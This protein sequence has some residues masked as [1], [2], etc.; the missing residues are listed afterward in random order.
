M[1]EQLRIHQGRRQRIVAGE[2]H[3]AAALRIQIHDADGE[4]MAQGKG[5]RVA[6]APG[7][8]EHQ[9]DIGP[10]QFGLR[11]YVSRGLEHIARQ[12]SGAKQGVFEQIGNTAR[13]GAPRDAVG[14]R[15]LHFHQHGHCQMIM[16]V[17]ADSGQVMLDVD[18]D[19]AQLLLVTDTRQHQQLRRLD[20]ARREYHL[21]AR[22]ELPGAAH[23]RTARTRTART[24]IAG[25]EH[26][27]AGRTSILDDDPHRPRVGQYR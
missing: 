9:L 16:V 27:Y 3:V 26:C 13:R 23:T 20:R 8:L 10:R 7:R 24:E 15:V 1:T 14:L 6:V 4:A 2:P 11:A 12:R 18:A 21:T 19:G 17:R 22:G 25:A 5:E